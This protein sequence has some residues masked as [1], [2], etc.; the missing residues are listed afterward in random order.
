MDARPAAPKYGDAPLSTIYFPASCRPE[1]SY[2]SYI[3]PVAQAIDIINTTQWM[4]RLHPR[5]PTTFSVDTD[6]PNHGPYDVVVGCD[7]MPAD[8][9]W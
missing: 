2:G 9:H 4:Q 7:A 6:A 1:R 5:H 8:G 3:M